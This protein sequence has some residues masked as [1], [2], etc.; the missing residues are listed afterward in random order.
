MECGGLD[1]N[2][3]C[4]GEVIN[5]LGWCCTEVLLNRAERLGADLPDHPLLVKFRDDNPLQSFR[6]LHNIDFYFLRKE[7]LFL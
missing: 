6:P 7:A 5:D 3:V 2:A 1:L 4:V